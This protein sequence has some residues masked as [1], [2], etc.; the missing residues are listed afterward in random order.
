MGMA[1]DELRDEDEVF[2]EGDIKYVVD[3]NL[4][5]QLKPIKVDYVNSA[6]GAGFSI[7]SNMAAGGSCGSGCSC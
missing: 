1:L 6:M 4:L 5:D 2:D 7:T 3:K